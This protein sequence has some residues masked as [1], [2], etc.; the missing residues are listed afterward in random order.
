MRIS[1]LR[2]TQSVEV[3]I[4][5]FGSGIACAEVK[6]SDNGTTHVESVQFAYADTM[7]AGEMEIAALKNAKRNLDD[8]AARVGSELSDREA[9][10]A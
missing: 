8:L 1:S 3:E 6:L 10:R 9:R 7:T 5:S 2:N 4:T